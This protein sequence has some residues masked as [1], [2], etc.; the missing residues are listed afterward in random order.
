MTSSKTLLITGL[1]VFLFCPRADAQIPGM[2]AGA[3]IPGVG[4]SIPGLG[5]TTG[6]GGV[7]GA[8]GA[9]A[10][11]GLCA[12]LKACLAGCKQKICGS[13]LGSLIN[14]GLAPYSS[15]SGG[16][17]PQL[18]PT[19]PSD[20][21]IA[22]LSKMGGPNG[23]SAVAA[24]VKQDEAEA[25]ARRAAVRYLSTVDCHYWP[26]A[27]VAIISALR[28]DKNECVRYEAA[29]ALLNGCCCNART[30]EALNIVVAGSEKDGKPSETSE[31]VRSVAL[32]ALQGCL[33]KFT[34]EPVAPPEAPEPLEAPRPLSALDPAFRRVAYYYQTLPTRPTSEV[35]ANARATVARAVE[36]TAASRAT[37]PTQPGERSVYHALTRAATVPAAADASS[38]TAPA[39]ASDAATQPEPARVSPTDG[40][41]DVVRTGRT[42]LP[43]ISTPTP[44][45]TSTS[46]PTSPTLGETRP[47]SRRVI[48]GTTPGIAGRSMVP[49]DRAVVPATARPARSS[50][51]SPGQRGL[52]GIIRDSARPRPGI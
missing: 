36:R 27:E 4:S 32:A 7:A 2:G 24:K 10:P 46:N 50:T 51:S 23:A 11:R 42:T 37:R 49:V 8:A 34:P 44:T 29:L 6:L 1:L 22:A 43:P 18:C 20:A 35:I 26:D 47:G 33:L 17:I 16:L 9:V 12:G 45:P 48:A 25:A 14:N 38:E 3:G 13:P 52:F 31:R 5:G 21:D 40:A 28:D 39:P 41:E 19:V 30:I 15:L